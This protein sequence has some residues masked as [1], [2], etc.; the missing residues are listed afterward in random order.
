MSES[1]CAQVTVSA[2]AGPLLA[3]T[4]LEHN[5][6]LFKSPGPRLLF[7]WGSE[8]MSKQIFGGLTLSLLSP[9]SCLGIREPG[10]QVY[11]VKPPSHPQKGLRRDSHSYPGA[12]LSS[13]QSLH[14]PSLLVLGSETSS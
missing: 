6:G 3:G 8:F 2:V 12:L 10:L 11:V 7:T 9:D 13:L 14:H 1:S 4:L 5:P